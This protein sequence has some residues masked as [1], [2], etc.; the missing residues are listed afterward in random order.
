MVRVLR[1][2]LAVWMVLGLAGLLLGGDAELNKPV[3]QLAKDLEV[4]GK[5]VPALL[6]G[7]ER[8]WP[9][10]EAEEIMYALRYRMKNGQTNPDD[11]GL[12]IGGKPGAIKTDGV[13]L[14]VKE[15]ARRELGAQELAALTPDLM[16][17]G[18]DMLGVAHAV[19]NKCPPNGRK[20]IKLWEKYVQDFKKDTRDFMNAVQKK[21]PAAIK[22]A[23]DKLDGTCIACHNDF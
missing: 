18:Y 16:Q 4:G 20:K 13:E 21:Q 9:K 12:G 14:M 6:K 5:N 15:L 22:A 1:P 2:Y 10:L 19:A 7:I 8:Q 23:A 3:R 11:A 17:A